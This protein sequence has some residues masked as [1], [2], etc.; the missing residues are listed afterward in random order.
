M[1]LSPSLPLLRGLQG[2][3]LQPRFSEQLNIL[4]LAS[5]PAFLSIKSVWTPTVAHLTRLFKGA[6][7]PHSPSL[8]RNKQDKTGSKIKRRIEKAKKE[9]KSEAG[10]ESHNHRTDQMNPFLGPF[11]KPSQSLLRGVWEPF[12]LLLYMYVGADRKVVNES[13]GIFPLSAW[14]QLQR[15]C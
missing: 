4:A 7:L 9:K 15:T 2:C 3:S 1:S 5:P 10:K 14:E 6:P 8:Q 12:Y 11:S 13:V